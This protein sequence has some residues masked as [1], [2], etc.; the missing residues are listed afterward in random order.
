LLAVRELHKRFGR[1]TVL[2][3]LSLEFVPGE[4]C[5]LLAPNGAGKSTTL[6]IV[7][8]LVRPD[9]GRGRIDFTF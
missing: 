8:G 7:T 6:R 4:I 9:R 1:N 3:G 2:K 5:G